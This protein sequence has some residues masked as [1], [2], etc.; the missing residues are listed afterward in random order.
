MKRYDNPKKGTWVELTKR[1]EIDA[2][3]LMPL[4]RSYLL[5]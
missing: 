4:V 3:E 1:P 2:E 5:P